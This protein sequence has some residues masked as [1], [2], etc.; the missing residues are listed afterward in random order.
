MDQNIYTLMYIN[1]GINSVEHEFHADSDDHARTKATAMC[2]GDEGLW[3]SILLFN[4]DGDVITFE[5]F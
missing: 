3:T 2:K 5:P 1:R 4:P